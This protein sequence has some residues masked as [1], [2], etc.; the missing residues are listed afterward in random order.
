MLHVVQQ[1]HA[2]H[3]VGLHLIFYQHTHNGVDNNIIHSLD[4]N[5]PIQVW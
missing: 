2:I 3:V 1:S 4:N 5:P